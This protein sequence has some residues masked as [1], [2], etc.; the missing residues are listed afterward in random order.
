MI[1]LYK[2]LLINVMLWRRPLPQLLTRVPVAHL[3]SLERVDLKI[4]IFLPP[5]GYPVHV[6]SYL[7]ASA[8]PG[9]ENAAVIA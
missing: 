5:R 3:P 8:S 4:R 9:I 1:G 6:D 7:G 2:L